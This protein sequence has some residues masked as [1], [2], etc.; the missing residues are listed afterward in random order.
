[1]NWMIDAKILCID[2]SE[3]EIL[4]DRGEGNEKINSQLPTLYKRNAG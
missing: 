3:I 2:N 4:T 1:M